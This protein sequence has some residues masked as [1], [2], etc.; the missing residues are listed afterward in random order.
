M[1]FESI[2]TSSLWMPAKSV[3][4][5]WDN[6]GMAAL[7]NPVPKLPSVAAFIKRRREVER[8]ASNAAASL[9]R[10]EFMRCS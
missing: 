8:E 5:A 2:V 3:L 1:P 10:S 9:A 7:A 4:I 6:T